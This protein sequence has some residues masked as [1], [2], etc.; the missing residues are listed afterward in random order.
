[1]NTIRLFLTK[2]DKDF[3]IK[4]FDRIAQAVISPVIKAEWHL[5]DNLS[6]TERGSDGFGSTGVSEVKVSYPHK[7]EKFYEPF[8]KPQE[9]ENLL[10]ETVVID[11]I[12][13][14]LFSKIEQFG[15]SVKI[16]F[17]I[18]GSEEPGVDIGSIFNHYV[19]MDY[20]MAFQRVTIDGHRFGKEMGLE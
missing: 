17:K 3:E 2:Y 5:T 12:Y 8:T 10:G 15:L 14:G 4:P 16:Y 9:M 20:L 1:M 7:V 18:F 13:K 6:E 11:K 19:E